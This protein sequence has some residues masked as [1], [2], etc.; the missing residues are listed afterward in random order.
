[1]PQPVPVHSLMCES[2]TGD[3]LAIGA[4]LGARIAPQEHG[5][6]AFWTPTSITTRHDGSRGLFPH[7]SLDRAKPGLLAVNSAGRRFV[8]EAVSYHD[9]VSAMF[10]SHKIEPSIPAYL[11]CDT[12]FLN[13]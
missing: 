13:K 8:N 4:R 7:L 11:I 5:E 2:N 10:A 3:G 9:F 1:M 6:G 12:A